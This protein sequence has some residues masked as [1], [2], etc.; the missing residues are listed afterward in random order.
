MD[1]LNPFSSDTEIEREIDQDARLHTIH[2]LV[3]SGLTHEEAERWCE[4][5]ENE[6][7]AAG[8]P[9]D[10]DFWDAGVHWIGE[11]RAAT[12]LRA[13]APSGCEGTETA[14]GGVPHAGAPTRQGR[15]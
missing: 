5:W 2:S 3:G 12:G 9:R 10:P 13:V 7:D 4:L 1:H 15:P 6:A 11:E 8:L 14:D